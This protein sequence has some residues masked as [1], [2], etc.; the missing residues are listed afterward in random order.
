MVFQVVDFQFVDLEG[1][2][3]QRIYH[4]GAWAACCLLAPLS[5][6]DYRGMR[7]GDF[8]HH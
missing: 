6:G 1:V 2:D 7:N 5:F 8:A 3:F 4:Y